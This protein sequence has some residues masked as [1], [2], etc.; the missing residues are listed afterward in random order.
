METGS[1]LLLLLA[2]LI[3]SALLTFPSLGRKT[4]VFFG[5]KEASAAAAASWCSAAAAD[6]LSGWNAPS[7]CL[8]CFNAFFDAVVCEGKRKASLDYAKD[9]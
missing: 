7:W 9:K 6:A 5:T 4:L 8:S 3:L 1:A 2:L